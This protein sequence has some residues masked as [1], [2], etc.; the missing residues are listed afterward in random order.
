M[1]VERMKADGN[2]VN[3]SVSFAIAV[4]VMTGAGVARADQVVQ[5]PLG[6]LLNGR[7]VTTLTQGTVVPWTVGVYGSKMDGFE[8]A[9]ASKFHKDPATLQTLPDDGTFPAGANHPLVV[10]NFSNDADPKSQQTTLIPRMQ[11]GMFMF[12]VP[13]ATYSKMYLFLTSAYG[14]SPL[15]ITLGY[16]ATTQTVNVT[17]PDFF[18]GVPVGTETPTLFNLATNLPNWRQD[19][20]VYEMGGHTIT[21]VELGPMAGQVL[22]TIKVARMTGGWLTLWGATGVATGA[23]AGLDGGAAPNGG[24]AD[25]GCGSAADAGGGSAT[26]AGGGS[27]T[28]AGATDSGAV[29][30]SGGAG[31]TPGGGPG[32]GTG[33]TT[34]GSGGAGGPTGGT[35]GQRAAPSSGGGCSVGDAPG[36]AAPFGAIAFGIAFV[37][38]ATARFRRPSAR[39][40]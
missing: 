14:A 24:A 38:V 39:A 17:V 6:Q 19:G 5:V 26:D 7:T 8:T 30:S 23:V 34:A 2:R 25:A 1:K 3:S 11:P 18:P 35:S 16:G 22:Q 36:A 29:A 9:A 33:G 15:T 27:T 28:D 4:A 10:L 31:G 13:A 40:E 32:G 12:P 37:L 20:S 21:G